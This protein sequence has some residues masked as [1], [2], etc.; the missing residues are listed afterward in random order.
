MYVTAQVQLA[1]RTDDSTRSDAIVVLGAAQY[2]GM[3]SP[4]FRA[5]LEHA[6]K[7]YRAGKAPLVVVAG[8]RLQ[9]DRYTEA[10]A[11]VRYLR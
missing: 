9:G 2:Q 7:L 1:G 6:Y 5:R 3:P 8:S 11:G 10:G 4:V